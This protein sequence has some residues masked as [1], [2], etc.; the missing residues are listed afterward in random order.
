MAAVP[1]DG[2]FVRG[3][4]GVILD[5]TPPEDVALTRSGG[6][7]IANLDWLLDSAMRLGG[8]HPRAVFEGGR[9][10]PSP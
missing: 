5:R 9:R 1:S 8:R 3:I 7:E 4:G 10:S 6:V 2:L